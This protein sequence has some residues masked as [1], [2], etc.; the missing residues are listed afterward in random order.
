MEEKIMNVTN[1]SSLEDY[2]LYWNFQK[3]KG[4]SSRKWRRDQ[5][6]RFL[7]S[8]PEYQRKPKQ[9]LNWILSHNPN[10]WPISNT[11]TL[12]KIMN[13]MPAMELQN[14][15]SSKF[16]D[17]KLNSNPIKISWNYKVPSNIDI[18]CWRKLQ[19]SRY[20]DTFPNHGP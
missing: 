5:I 9:V 4:C 6:S 13:R 20:L 1:L 17:T 16:S 7:K 2:T 12:S 3:P 19:L 15:P 14:R 18:H 10:P 11:N 8:Y